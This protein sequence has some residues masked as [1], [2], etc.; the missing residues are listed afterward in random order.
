MTRA[1]IPT[2]TSSTFFAQQ[3]EDQIAAD[4]GNAPPPENNNSEGR[5]RLWSAP[6]K[7]LAWVLD[8][9]ADGNTPR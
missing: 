7:T 4:N 2:T 3:R 9:I 1:R 5:Q 6:G 8:H